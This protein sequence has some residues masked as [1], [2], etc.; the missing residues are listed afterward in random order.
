MPS[1]E[2]LIA[3]LERLS[4]RDFAPDAAKRA[5]KHVDAAVKATARA[6]TTPDGE[7]WIPKKD[8]SRAM[9]N[10]ADALSTSSQGSIVTVMLKPPEVFHNFSKS[11]KRQVL[12]DAGADEMPRGVVEALKNAADEAFLEA[13]GKSGSR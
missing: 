3:T 12:P 8:G 10:A 2:D 7:P 5:V 13:T 9:V 1:I 11:H 6:G 4:G